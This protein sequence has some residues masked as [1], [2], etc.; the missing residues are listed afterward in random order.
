MYGAIRLLILLRGKD[1]PIGVA[2]VSRGKSPSSGRFSEAPEFMICKTTLAGTVEVLASH[3]EEAAVEMV[4]ER[5][6][7]PH[8][9][10]R[11]Q[12]EI[13]SSQ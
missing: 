4:G 9:H 2:S 8:S 12:H 13:C 7:P 11:L 3:P 10:Y 6:D 1:V 5:I